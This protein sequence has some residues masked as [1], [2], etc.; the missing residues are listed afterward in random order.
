METNLKLG[1]IGYSEGNG[2]PFSWSAIINGYNKKNL[3]NCP[4]PIIREYL[5]YEKNSNQNIKNVN[6]SHVWTQNIKYTKLISDFSNIP[7]IV[8]EFTDMIGKVDA[9]LLAR[10]DYENHL[11]YSKPFLEA[12]IPI[13]IDKPIAVETFTL[14]KIL[15][16]Q[17]YKGQIFSHSALRY[18]NEFN[19]DQKY[20][21]SFGKIE[22]IIAQSPKDWCHYSIHIIEPVINSFQLDNDFSIISKNNYEEAGRVLNVK[23]GNSL[24][25][26]FIT[27]GSSNS[28]FSIEIIGSKKSEVI[29]FKDTYSAF[30]SCILDFI[31]RLNNNSND[32]SEK[33]LYLIVKLIEAGI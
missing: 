7:F 20:I 23:W 31:E 21:D 22:E 33:E 10:D 27:T 1:L 3:E 19:F 6:V 17:S 5:S 30:K 9:V 11:K 28:A 26:K 16:L 32:Y 8:D 12:G 13:Y 24:S 29:N 4:Y 18:A 2:H 14:D 25:V 15:K